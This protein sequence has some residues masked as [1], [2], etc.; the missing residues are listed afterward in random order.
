[1]LNLIFFRRLTHFCLA[2]FLCT[3]T[4][5]SA[6][7]APEWQSARE[8]TKRLS[9]AACE[10][11]A[12][13][14]K[15]LERKA[16]RHK[17]P[18][19]Q[20]SLAW[21]MVNCN[22]TDEKYHKSLPIRVDLYRQAAEAGYP[23]ARSNYGIHLFAGEGVARDRD[24]G[25]SH[26]LA[27]VEDGYQEAALYLARS[28]L[29][30]HYGMA[31]SQEDPEV[32][33]ELLVL[34]ESTG[35]DATQVNEAWRMLEMEHP[36]PG[37][38]CLARFFDAADLRDAACPRPLFATTAEELD[39]Y[40]A[41]LNDYELPPSFRPFM[42]YGYEVGG[43]DDEYNSEALNYCVADLGKGGNQ[44][45][46]ALLAEMQQPAVSQF[47][48]AG[49]TA[50]MSDETFVAAMEARGFTC[51]PDPYNRPGADCS[52]NNSWNSI[53]KDQ[54]GRVYVECEI[55]DGCRKKARTIAQEIVD[56]GMVEKLNNEGPRV[57][58]TVGPADDKIC[59]QENFASQKPQ[60]VLYPP[61]TY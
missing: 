44:F 52:Q 30:G 51:R 60:I 23:L 58:C 21:L 41:C 19:A 13:A 22:Y 31:L 39:S 54:S 8:A 28:I 36:D 38:Y 14:K 26:V 53:N 11:D 40:A 34:A 4:S 49:I 15:E 18:T 17:E 9:K 46:V 55:F 61:G 24:A 45:A 1:M 12:A 43:W 57:W 16:L 59:V 6:Q 32:V 48:I 35:V 56:S 47:A 5:I 42:E 27:A 3:S 7:M 37:Q 50:F 33:Y 29:R 10:G 20:T 25:I 2:I